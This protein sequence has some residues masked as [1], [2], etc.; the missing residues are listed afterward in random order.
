MHDARLSE[1]MGVEQLIGR[2]CAVRIE[3]SSERGRALPEEVVD[4]RRL[5]RMQFEPCA[6]LMIV[7]EEHQAC[8]VTGVFGCG[9]G[10]RVTLRGQL[11]E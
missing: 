10:Q 4:L 3:G 7:P 6:A 2:A 11:S 1:Q 9:R 5:Q 8:V